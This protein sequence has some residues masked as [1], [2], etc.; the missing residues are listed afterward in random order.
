MVDTSAPPKPPH[1][2]AKWKKQQ[3]MAV[4]SKMAISG[5]DAAGERESRRDR[6]GQPHTHEE[7]EKSDADSNLP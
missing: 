5:R 4:F 3:V 7:D 1:I 6:E 2:T